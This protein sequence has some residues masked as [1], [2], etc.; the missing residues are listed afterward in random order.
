MQAVSRTALYRH[1]DADG[2][3][4]YDLWAATAPAYEAGDAFDREVGWV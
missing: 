3:L 1:F 4:L 2:A